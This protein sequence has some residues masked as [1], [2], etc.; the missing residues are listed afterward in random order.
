MLVKMR[1]VAGTWVMA[2]FSFLIIISFG[3]FG[4]GDIFRGRTTNTVATVD[5]VDI[6]ADAVTREFRREMN[7][8]QSLFG[9][10]LN[11][12]RARQLGLGQRALDTVIARTLY[13]LEARD[14]GL[15]VGDDLVAK[16]IRDAPSFQNNGRFDR[17]LF[18]SALAV[19]GL[20][21]DQY[22]ALLREDTRRLQLSGAVTAAVTVPD[23]LVDTLYRYRNERRSAAYFVITPDLVAPAPEPDEA[24]LA[25]YHKA[26]AKKFTAPEYLKLTLVEV[27]A[28]DLI[29]QIAVSESEIEAEYADR[30]AEFKISERRTIEQMLLPDKETANKAYDA[31]KSGRDFAAVAKDLTGAAAAD[32]TLGTMTRSDLSAVIGDAADDVFALAA[33]ESS[34][35]V[36]TPLGWHIFRVNEVT[37]ATLQP[38]DEVRDRL[39]EA[40]ARRR[41]LDTVYKVANQLVDTL[42][43]GAT[44]EEAADQFGLRRIAIAAVDRRG[45]DPSGKSVAAL[46]KQRKIIDTAF[47]TPEGETSL[48]TETDDGNFF[49]V[50]VDGITPAA[51]K[52]LDAVHDQV[53]DA[54]RRD[55]LVEMAATRATAATEQLNGGA[56]ID[57]VATE[58]G[59]KLFTSGA[60]RRD[61]DG[62]GK[63]FSPALVAT[64]FTLEPGKAAAGPSGD[65]GGS[66]IIRLKSVFPADPNADAKGIAA[67]RDS[68]RAGIEADVATEYRAALKQRFPVSIDTGAVAALF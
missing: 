33:G 37:T 43:G 40:I 30:A 65:G 12:D 29:D 61:G 50:R 1:K 3:I 64:L 18:G 66:A 49:I 36:K 27:T 45:E 68:L 14:L 17:N 42:A 48:L 67:L 34:A 62:A 23:S 53:R 13:D 28:D 22:V 8:L 38:L 32:L 60:I 59:A 54:W 7:R 10:D 35:P 19:Q 58:I 44:L 24:A 5:N 11:A 2:I 16:E 25:D 21:E 15:G 55:K 6:P 63:V 51:L 26:N 52:P 46:A 9:G 56:A 41:A 57:A 47:A 31:L 20:S 39:R 4:I